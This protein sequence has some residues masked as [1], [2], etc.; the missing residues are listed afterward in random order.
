MTTMGEESMPRQWR[1]KTATWGVT[2]TLAFA[3]VIAGPLP[4]V[5]DG[6]GPPDNI[7][8]EV[9]EDSFTV[10]WDPVAGAFGYDVRHGVTVRRG[11]V[12]PSATIPARWDT[13]IEV[14]VRTRLAPIH[15]GPD[16]VSEFSEP[17]TVIVQLPD[18]Y[19][20]PSAP[21][22]LRPVTDS[23]GEVAFID[24]DPPETSFGRL[25][26]RL[27]S[28]WVNYG[29]GVVWTTT[30][31]RWQPA[32]V[33]FMAF[34]ECIIDPATTYTFYVTATDQTGATSPPSDPI[35]VTTPPWDWSPGAP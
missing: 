34:V 28:S 13:P 14:S 5:A 8:V 1:S 35:T 29:D 21:A 19:T 4:A 24:W 10:E 27:H 2:L 15:R 32:S 9:H 6:T 17:I 22:N 7:R 12:E 31:G 25:T 30:T 33:W 20:T 18:G 11:G 3:T 23:T 26:Y 16:D